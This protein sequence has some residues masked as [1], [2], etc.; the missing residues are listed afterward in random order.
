MKVRMEAQEALNA[1]RS[2]AERLLQPFVKADCMVEVGDDGQERVRVDLSSDQIGGGVKLLF[3]LE[4]IS[5]AEFEGLRRAICWLSERAVERQGDDMKLQ[6]ALL[7]LQSVKGIGE[8][9]AEQLYKH[10]G[11]Y[12]AG[13]LRR[14]LARAS[15]RAKLCSHPDL[16]CSKAD[17]LNWLEQLDEANA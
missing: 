11:I 16:Q 13:Q 14:F 1:V 4:T 15:N 2:A 5:E 10:L 6:S 9:T 12:T 17:A 3:D 8:R 7:S